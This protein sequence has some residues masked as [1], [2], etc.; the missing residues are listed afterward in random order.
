VL[1]FLIV[2]GLLGRFTG[3]EAGTYASSPVA[4]NQ[5]KR[6][7]ISVMQGAF[8]IANRLLPEKDGLALVYQQ[9]DRLEFEALSNDAILIILTC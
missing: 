4:K 7:F 2:G 5:T 1:Q 3:W 8:E 9:A 6:V